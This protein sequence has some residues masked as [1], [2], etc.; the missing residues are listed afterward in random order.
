[1]KIITFMFQNKE[2][3]GFLHGDTVTEVLELDGTPISSVLD[4]IDVAGGDTMSGMDLK[5]LANCKTGDAFSVEEVAFLAPIPWP[6]RNLF[7]LGMNYADHAKEVSFTDKEE[8]PEVP[9]FPVYF[10]KLAFPASPDQSQ[11]LYQ[12]ELTKML[13]YEVELAVII[14]R[15]GKDIPLAEAM[16]YVFGYTIANDV[17][18]RNL[19]G[20]HGQWFKGK[21][22]DGYAPMGPYILTADEMGDPSDLQLQCYVNDELRQNANTRDMVFTIAEVISDL[23]KGLTLRKGDIILTGTPAGVGL[24]FKPYRFL[25]PGDVVR[26]KI[27]KLGEL[28]T[29]IV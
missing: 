4:L 16:D 29:Y 25:N 8:K 12:E 1:M 10:S 19:Q 3:A 13:D 20:K 7:C 22:V 26:C 15:D 5:K 9:K 17:S 21:S 14:G 18:A 27:D 11:L 24:G 23:S 28:T 2:K 6:R